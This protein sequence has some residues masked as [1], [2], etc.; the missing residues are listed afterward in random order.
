MKQFRKNGPAPKGAPT[1]AERILAAADKLFYI[2]GIRAIGVDTIAAEAGVSKRTLY[3]HYPSKDALIAAYLTARFRHIAPSDAPAAEQILGVFDRLERVFASTGF[4]GCPFVNAVAELS[5]PKH[6]A[7]GIAIQFKE[8]R[9]QWF[10]SLLESLKVRDPE[11][12]ATQLAI[13]TDGAIAT[14][15]VRGDP[16]YARSARAAAETLLRAGGARLSSAN[17]RRRGKPE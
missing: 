5:D 2:R 6:P 13:L 12:L 9:R 4:R 11:A 3:N 16:A 7:S 15:L 17:P 14:A 10:K 8:Q 1:A